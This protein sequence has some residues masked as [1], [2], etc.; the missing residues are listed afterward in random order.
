MRHT[1]SSVP[2][3]H[4]KRV[5][6]L[7][8]NTDRDLL[9]F[10]FDAVKELGWSVDHVMPDGVD[11]NDILQLACI[12]HWD[13]AF[14]IVNNVTYPDDVSVRDGATQLIHDLSRFE[15]PI[16]TCYGW[17]NDDAFV[18]DLMAVGATAAFRIPCRTVTIQKAF[19]AALTSMR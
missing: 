3:G 7:V 6:L 10:I 2:R 19:C 18:D 11:D 16:V 13:L 9:G 5:V 17:P 14:L 1:A 8:P 15:K 4:G 12:A